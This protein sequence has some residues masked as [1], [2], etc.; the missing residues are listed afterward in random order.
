MRFQIRKPYDL[1]D[2]QDYVYVSAELVSS[3]VI[4]AIRDDFFMT[5][6]GLLVIFKCFIQKCR[7]FNTN[8][9]P[10]FKSS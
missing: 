8:V 9:S 1:A 7:G 5:R 10:I 3:G 2:A 6:P 4:D